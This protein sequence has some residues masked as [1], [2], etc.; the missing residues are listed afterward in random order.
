MQENTIKQESQRRLNNQRN[1]VELKKITIFL[2]TV[3]TFLLLLY[4]IFTSKNYKDCIKDRKEFIQHVNNSQKLLSYYLATN[5]EKTFGVYN[6]QQIM[7]GIIDE[8]GTKIL[9][10]KEKEITPIVD[11]N[12]IIEEKGFKYYLVI[13]E[14]LKTILNLVLNPVENA[15]Y[16]ISQDGNLK[17]KFSKLPKW[18][19]ESISYYQV[20]NN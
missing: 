5:I 15:T 12:S 18:F 8:T 13:D 2:L 14:N 3:L 17:L 10:N 20:G 19:D 16:Y 6:E 9:D 1:K 11:I 4:T 7:T